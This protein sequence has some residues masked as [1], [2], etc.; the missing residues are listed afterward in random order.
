M[1]R[2][3]P[4]TKD[5]SLLPRALMTAALTLLVAGCMTLD[6]NLFDAERVTEYLNPADIDTAWHVRGVIPE[7][8]RELVALNSLDSN[9]IYGLFVRAVRDTDGPDDPHSTVIYCHGK[10]RC[11]NRFWGRVELL[12]E[13]GFDVFIFDYQ[14]YGMSEGSPS[15]AACYADAEAA[16]AYVLKRPDVDTSRIVLYGWSLGSFMARHL[17]VDVRPPAAVILENPMASVSGVAKE[18]ALLAIPGSFLADADFD[19]ETRIAMGDSA[20]RLLIV[21]GNEDETAVPDRCA[22][23]LYSEA[24][25]WGELDSIVVNGANHSDIPELMGY[26]EYRRAMSEFV[27]RQ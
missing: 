3:V 20:T 14:G 8:L 12:W 1:S 15:G 21:Y 13:A 18:G 17:A 10:S 4:R 27:N 7:S 24:H 6:S 5:K 2:K 9:T 23:L 16:L 19:N 25:G 26:D 22:E 11:I